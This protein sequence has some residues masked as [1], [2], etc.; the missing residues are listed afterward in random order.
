M[1]FGKILKHHF[2][3]EFFLRPIVDV[4]CTTWKE[5]VRPKFDGSGCERERG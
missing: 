5:G 2:L 4:Y 3:Q 1:F